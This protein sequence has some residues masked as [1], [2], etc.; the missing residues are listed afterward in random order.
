MLFPKVHEVNEVW[1]QVCEGVEANRL[2]IA[3]KVST[4]CQVAG[5]PTRLVCVYTKDFTDVED[6]KRVLHALV[7]M[8]LVA[9]DM[10][11]GIAYKC[12][13]YTYLNI[14]GKNEYGLPASVYGSKEMLAES[15]LLATHQPMDVDMTG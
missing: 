13:A 15:A 11:R 3:A 2:G 7:E 14:Y 9:A 8:G 4:S 5:D 10:P 6:V 1:R 12:D